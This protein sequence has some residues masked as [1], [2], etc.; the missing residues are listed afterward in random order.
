MSLQSGELYVPLR[1]PAH[2]YRTLDVFSRSHPVSVGSHTIECTPVYCCVASD[3]CGKP[4]MRTDCGHRTTDWSKWIKV[5]QRFCGLHIGLTVVYRRSCGTWN[6]GIV[7]ARLMCDDTP[8]LHVNNQRLVF[9]QLDD[10]YY[11][12]TI[13]DCKK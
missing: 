7:T 8:L 5:S 6:V 11:E 13:E 9:Q 10:K 12:L 2:W 3:L 1:Y 4:I